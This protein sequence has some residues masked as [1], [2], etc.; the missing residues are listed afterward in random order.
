MEIIVYNGSTQIKKRIFEEYS[1]GNLLVI[2]PK[3]RKEVIII[4]D[5]NA[6]KKHK[7]APGIYC[8]NQHFWTV[9]NLR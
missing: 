4:I 5:E 2:C 1:S 9:F 3:C 7:K 8:P 6:V